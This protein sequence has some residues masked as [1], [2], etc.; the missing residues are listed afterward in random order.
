MTETRSRGHHRPREGHE[1][2]PGIRSIGIDDGPFDRTRKADVLVA[3]A[4][5][6]GGTWFDGLLTCRVRRDGRN[7]TDR[8]VAML[9]GSKFS[10]QLRYAF[11]D[12]IA[13]GGFNIL[14][15]DRLHAET[16]L[17]LLVIMR[18]RPDLP[19]MRR[20]LARL[21]RSEQRW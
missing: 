11:L 5:Y 2:K 13:L 14:D 12:G 16:G 20:A 9:T 4:V 21:G 10:D 15:L 1:I 6:R 3:G 18:R 17:G 7:A 19:A 8:L